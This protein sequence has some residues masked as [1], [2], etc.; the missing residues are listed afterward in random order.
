MTIVLAIIDNELHAFGLD[1]HSVCPLRY[2]MRAIGIRKVGL[3]LLTPLEGSSD[4][5]W[6]GNH[7]YNKTVRTREKQLTK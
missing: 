1:R 6:L 5:D 4:R 7:V 2:G 3:F